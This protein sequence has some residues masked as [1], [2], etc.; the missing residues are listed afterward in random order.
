MF[1][2]KEGEEASREQVKTGAR[3]GTG[4]PCGAGL[5]LLT[6]S[7]LHIRLSERELEK[8]KRRSHAERVVMAADRLGEQELLE[9]IEKRQE[10]NERKSEKKKRRGG[11][12]F[13][14]SHA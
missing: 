8:E 13:S 10:R 12:S 9:W 5:L 4:E 14:F 1:E 3:A 11:C 7:N 2:N 6:P